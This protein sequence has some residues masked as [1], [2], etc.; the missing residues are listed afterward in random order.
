MSKVIPSILFSI[1]IILNSCK[2]T[3]NKTLQNIPH[4]VTTTSPSIDSLN[5]ILRNNINKEEAPIAN[6][7]TFLYKYMSLNDKLDETYNYYRQLVSIT[8]EAQKELPW[9][10]KIPKQIY[11]HFI[12][13]HRTNNETLDTSRAFFYHQLK[14]RVKNLTMLEAALEV[15]HWCHE[16]VA[17][18][19]SDS[20]TLSPMATYYKGY[21]RCGEES[22]F[23]VAAL[24]AVQIPARQTYTPRW[25]HTDDNHAWVEFWANGKWYFYGACEPVAQA[26]TAWFTEPAKRAMLVTSTVYGPYPSSPNI[27]SSNSNSSRTNSL[28]VYAPTKI[29][30]VKT[31][32]RNNEIVSG[33]KVDFQLYNYGEFYTLFRDETDSNGLAHFKTGLGDLLIWA[34]TDSSNAYQMHRNNTNDTLILTLK[35]IADT[36]YSIKLKYV[37]PIKPPVTKHNTIKETENKLKLA[38]EDSLR[39]AYELSFVDSIKCKQFAINNSIDAKQLWPLIKTSRANANELFLFIEQTPINKKAMAL[40]ILKQI[41]TK[42]LQDTKAEILLD[43]VLNTDSFSKSMAISSEIYSKYIL[44]PRIRTEELYPWRSKLKNALGDSMSAKDYFYWVKNTIRVDNNINQSGVP[45]DPVQVFRYHIADKISQSNLLIALW[46]SNGIAGRLEEGTLLPQYYDQGQWHDVYFNKKQSKTDIGNA[47]LTL[48]ARNIKDKLLYY[49]HFTLAKRRNG[50]YYTLEYP[51]DKTLS[52]FDKALKLSPG[53]YRLCTG[54]RLAD[55]SVLVHFN[56]FHLINDEHKTIEVYQLKKHSQTSVYG[57]ID[58][59]PFIKKTNTKNACT[60]NNKAYL[61]LLWY[62]P[63]NE[64][65]KHII[66]AIGQNSSFLKKQNIHLYLISE[67][68]H[69]PISLDANYFGKL[70]QTTHYLVDSK[71]HFLH[72]CQQACHQE[73]SEEFPVLYL[74]NPTD[75]VIFISQGYQIGIDETLKNLFIH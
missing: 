17:Y 22:V 10:S 48:K 69:K 41:S 61:L 20:R 68:K 23:T 16:H 33:A 11:L 30:W 53:E 57:K 2:S 56:F 43:H 45:I 36:N 18:Q 8:R 13:P 51:W 34:H 26:N 59:L 44:N 52:S 49:K 73:S 25:A 71:L 6:D 58:V 65:S 12:L 67:K 55:G 24:R 39:K 1:L 70:P 60:T 72:Q 62:K 15:N 74:I 37:P 28:Y 50:Q 3:E 66:E 63:N 38:Y 42:D 46:R 29:V 5:T 19:S 7:L 32:N 75:E 21:G 54:K 31:I 35:A 14:D 47:I 64:P 4:T 9:G 27:L 40:D